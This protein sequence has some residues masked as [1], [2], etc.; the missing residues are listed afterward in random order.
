MGKSKN[1]FDSF[2]EDVK[3]TTLMLKFRLEDELKLAQFDYGDSPAYY[4]RKNYLEEKAKGEAFLK[5]IAVVK[6]HFH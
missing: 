6:E 1:I 3:A 5:L 4:E 2:L